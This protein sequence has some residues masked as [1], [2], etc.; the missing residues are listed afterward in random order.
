ME[1]SKLGRTGLDVS[2]CC[3]GTMTWGTQNTESD[4]HEQM[5]YAVEQGVNFFDTAEMYSIPPT[6][7][8]YGK[9]ETIIG[10]WFKNRGKRDDI[11]LASKVAGRNK[12]MNWMRD[13][14]DSAEL[15]E[16][17]INE[18]VE[19]SLKRLQ[20]D[21]ID[22]YQ[23]HW[24]DRPV[25]LFGSGHFRKSD[26]YHKFEDI[27][28]TL[29]RH[30]DKGNIRFIG[31]S[32]ETPYGVMRFVAE[33]EAKG[34]PRIHSIQNAYS[35]VNRTFEE[36][37]EEACMQEDVGL[38]SYSPLAQGYLSGKYRNGAEPE[39]SRLVLFGRLGRYQTKTAA[40]AFEK[41]FKLCDEHGIDPTEL[42]LKFCDTRSFMASTIIGAT[43][44]DQLKADIAAFDFAWN[45]DLEK[46][47]NDIH[48]DCPNP[49]P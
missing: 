21:Y 48:S 43:T 3:L 12:H 36:G 13:S 39:G 19:N 41:Y 24:P 37:L 38:L 47:V 18:A 14:G 40:P 22:L 26:K 4:G 25:R 6:A 33:S 1:Y 29:Q 35:L 45:D 11:I 27:L 34:L 32:N 42:A 44:L 2:R 23:L 16:A 5:D 46:A 10:T 8:S 20:T 15:S 17:Q 28:G 9:T 30:V 31:V 7:E 49:C